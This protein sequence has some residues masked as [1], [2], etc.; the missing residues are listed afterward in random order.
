M[1]KVL[2]NLTE[3][4]Y[5]RL[6]ALAKKMGA[7]PLDGY[8]LRYVYPLDGSVVGRL[9]CEILPYSSID[10]YGARMYKGVAAEAD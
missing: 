1:K 3:E 8:Q 4:Q 7:K 5:Q 6:E 2:F 9:T 10:D